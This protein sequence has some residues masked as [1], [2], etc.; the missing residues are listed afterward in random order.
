MAFTPSLLVEIASRHQ[1]YLE[2]LKTTETKKTIAFLQGIDRAVRAR[3]AGGELTAFG[4]NRLEKLLV[5][6]AGD[7]GK[8]YKNYAS[9]QID[10]DEL[11]GYEAGFE[12]RSLQQVIDH[13]FD[14]PSTSQLGAVIWSKPLDVVGPDGGKLLADFL[15]GV[16]RRAREQITGAIRSGYYAGET[17][18]QILQRVRGTK[19][20]GYTDGIIARTGRDA[21]IVVRTAIQHV[22]QVARESLWES[23]ADVVKGVRWV[24]TLDGRTTTQC[25]TLDGEVFAVGVGPRPPIHPGCRSTTVAALDDRFALLREGAT[26]SARDMDGVV[27]KA[28]AKTTYYEWLKKQPAEFQDSVIG[29]KRGE[30]LRKGGLS[31]KR[32]AELQLSNNFV[33]LTLDQM[34]ALEPLAFKRAGI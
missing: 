14:V 9:G 6:I 4:K 29:K 12:Q 1:V 10:F 30:L 8:A 7:I 32:F 33:A 18:S 26:R 23:N 21:N 11:A 17:N 15:K 20:A 31:A 28:G 34:R 13:E 16:D 24:S 3:I 2:G 25:R 27:G 19:A 22:S 5:V